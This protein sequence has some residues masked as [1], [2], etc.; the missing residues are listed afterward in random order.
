MKQISIFLLLFISVLILSC[1]QNNDTNKQPIAK[2]HDN[3]LYLSDIREIIPNNKTKEDSLLIAKNYINNWIKKQLLLKKAELNLPEGMK[4][5]EKEIED[6]RSSLLIYRYQ[7][8]LID[9]KLDTVVDESEMRNYYE[10]NKSNFILD[11]VLIKATYI[12]LPINSPNIDNVKKWYKSDNEEHFSRLEDYCYQYAEIFDNFNGDWVPLDRINSI[13]P[14]KIKN[15]KSFLKYNK[16]I[17]SE[18]SLN[19]HLLKIND[20]RL[21]GTE[22]PFNFVEDKINSLI[23]NKRKHQLLEKLE[24]DIYNEALNHKEFKIY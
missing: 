22:A 17:E 5:V 6:Y 23:L 18:D 11:Q 3:Y 14:K 13:I 19:L 1:N 16:H 15:P 9:Q 10:E 12:K 20:Y 4:D 24:K 2:I 7:Q 21:K 8:Q